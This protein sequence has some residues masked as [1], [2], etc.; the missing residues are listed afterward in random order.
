VSGDGQAGLPEGRVTRA[1]AARALGLHKSTLS[2]L[3]RD[4]PWLLDADGLVDAVEVAA[5]RA[6]TLNPKLQTRGPGPWDPQAFDHGDASLPLGQLNDARV[7]HESA[8]AS[9]A[10]LALAERMGQTLDR[11]AVEAA[12]AE[13]AELMRQRGAQLA[14]D[15][16]EGLAKIDNAR[17]MEHALNELFRDAMLAM[18]RDLEAALEDDTADDAA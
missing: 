12:L 8:R 18:A 13:A 14:A 3:C 4:A 1:A 16:A 17:E 10:E 2:R 7:R 11:A 15:R 9:S 6:S 5:F